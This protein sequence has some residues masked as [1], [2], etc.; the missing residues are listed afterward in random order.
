MTGEK[1][2]SL[3]SPSGGYVLVIHG[4]AGTM[5][6]KGSTFEQQAAYKT[7]LRAA[8]EAV[9]PFAAHEWPHENLFQ[10]YKVLR[11]GGEAMDAVVA[12]VTSMEGGS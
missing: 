11:D 12:A 6:K 10:G 4:G 1:H 3:H 5:S 7:S 8:L 2:S 9:S